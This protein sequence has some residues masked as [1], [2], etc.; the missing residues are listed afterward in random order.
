MEGVAEM[1]TLVAVEIDAGAETA[2]VPSVVRY[3]TRS[4][5]TSGGAGVGVKAK[6]RALVLAQ[7]SG[8]LAE[9]PRRKTRSSGRLAEAPRRKTRSNGRLQAQNPL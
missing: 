3:K 5:E 6:P 7:T 4:F 8:R 9:G 2:V 1:A